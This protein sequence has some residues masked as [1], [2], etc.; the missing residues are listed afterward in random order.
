M[1]RSSIYI[2]KTI[3]HYSG[4]LKSRHNQQSHRTHNEKAK[5]EDSKLSV[6]NKSHD[7]PAVQCKDTLSLDYDYHA[8]YSKRKIQSN[9][10]RYKELPDV[11]DEDSEDENG[12]LSAADFQQLLSRPVSSGDHFT[13]A[14]ERSWLQ[15][16]DEEKSDDGT[17]ASNLFKLNIPNLNDGLTRLPFYLRHDFSTDLFTQEEL[18][19]MAE[20][21]ESRIESSKKISNDLSIETELV[22]RLQQTNVQEASKSTASS[23]NS[24]KIKTSTSAV[25][26]SN[27]TV[28][29]KPATKAKVSDT[30]D[31][32]AWLDDILN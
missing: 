25:P 31:I 11:D 1:K 30:E 23:S 27:K 8:Q 6:A 4:H 26:A 20:R 18:N 16:P 10:D 9:S 24:A 13:F 19:D 22:K 28:T 21:A 5:T 7:L 14:A 29:S 15:N 12:Q 2:D 17:M 3:L 32:Q